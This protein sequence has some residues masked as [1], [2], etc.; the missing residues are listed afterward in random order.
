MRGS[1]AAS[2]STIGAAHHAERQSSRVARAL[3][4]LAILGSA[5]EAVA[6]ASAAPVGD[7][8]FLGAWARGD[9]KTHVRIE[10]CGPE[11]CGVN[12]WVKPGVAG[13]KVGDR[14]IASVKPVGPGRW[15][16]SAFDPQRDRRYAMR[17]HVAGNQLTTQGCI[18]GGMMCQS[19]NWT[20][21][22]HAK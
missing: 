9:G 22:G 10:R 12:T 1:I 2:A 11:Y 18:F 3:A 19:M 8:A 5:G 17:V 4:F 6:T 15:S 16:G 21:L 13:E 20:R 7:P 14:L